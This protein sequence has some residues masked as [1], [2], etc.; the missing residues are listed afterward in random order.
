MKPQ[1]LGKWIDL[2][3]FVTLCM[4]ISTGALLEFTLPE[5]S[6]RAAVWGLTRHGWGDVHAAA[7][8]LFLVL[9]SIHLLLHWRYIRSAV[10]GRVSREQGY[11]LAL[12]LVCLITLLALLLA[13][14]FSPVELNLPLGRGWRWHG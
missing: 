10:L 11:R 4:M 5:R 14:L 2:L 12:G 1:E 9:M 6:G 8:L 7:A 3:A 13:P